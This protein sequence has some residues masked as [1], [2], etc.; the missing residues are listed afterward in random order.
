MEAMSPR[1][2]LYRSTGW[3]WDAVPSV[4]FEYDRTTVEPTE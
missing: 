2:A 1:W 3:R 4:M